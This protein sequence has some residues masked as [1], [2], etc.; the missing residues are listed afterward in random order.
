MKER[1]EE[2]SR[3]TSRKVLE[4]LAGRRRRSLKTNA[5]KAL[6]SLLIAD[7]DW[8]SRVSL[9]VPSVGSRIRE[10][11]TGKFGGFDIKCARGDNN[12]VFSRKRKSE[13]TDQPTFYRLNPKS[14][15]MSSLRKVF[16]EVI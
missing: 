9:R 14:V 7:G 16:G 1:K 3:T 5:Q 11:R 15:T 2:M 8:V 13:I 6:F 10:L 4:F 12:R